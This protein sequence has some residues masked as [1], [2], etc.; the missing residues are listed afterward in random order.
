MYH[1][2]LPAVPF[3]KQEERN[4]GVDLVESG[5]WLAVVISS[6]TA[7]MASCEWLG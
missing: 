5:T 6:S 7:M 1:D 4:R 3:D 2:T